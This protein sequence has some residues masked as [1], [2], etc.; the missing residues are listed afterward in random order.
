[1]QQQQGFTTLLVSLILVFLV[2]LNVVIGSKS[3]N[4]EVRTANNLYRTEAAFENAEQGVR[5]MWTQ[6]N[7][8]LAANPSA[9]LGNT[10]L[11]D[12]AYTANFCASASS[13]CAATS[14]LPF[15]FIKS[16]GVDPSGATRTISQR[17][18][19]N[20]TAGKPPII[21]TPVTDALTA[22][23][24]I[25]VGGNASV[26]SAKSG[27]S[28]TTSGSGSVSSTSTSDFYQ[29]TIVNGVET[30]LYAANGN[31]IKWTTDEFFMHYF[32]GL[33]PTTV[34]NYD[35]LRSLSD[36]TS[37][38]LAQQAGY[39]K[40]E[41]KASIAA[42]SDGYICSSS[43][44]NA[45]LSAAYSSG[46]R[47]MWLTA[48]GMKINANVVL[49]SSTDPVIIFVMESG[50]VQINGTSKIYGVVYVDVPEISST[51]TSVTGS[52][53]CSCTT[54]ITYNK[55][56]K[57]WT[58]PIYT[59]T[60]GYETQWCSNSA[61]QNATAAQKCTPSK[62]GGAKTGDKSTCTYSISVD[63]G[64]LASTGQTEVVIEVLGTWDNSGGG[65]ALIEGAA[66]T[67]GNY[68]TTGGIE[69]V[70]STGIINKWEAGTPGTN[71]LTTSSR[72]WS[73]MN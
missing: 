16:T 46:K 7:A 59:A 56:A 69:I 60:P 30:Y 64:D 24:N 45:D 65:N 70:K 51:V 33:C 48:G 43:C 3:A 9:A 18:S 57:I 36:T 62:P 50:T 34:S 15:P 12:G 19:Y 49:G 66:L 42:R 52:A 13:D 47:L 21:S 28:V 17:V 6:L 68:S 32:G 61:C 39:C 35:L 20:Y 26:T 58:D 41:V 53:S 37:V 38:E 73:D 44:A 4:L 10:K 11:T 54:S 63:T 1:M 31:K 72:G 2:T 40:A 14:T 29:K 71:T 27:G 8:T 5:S 25:A 55:P 67:S 23:G 22:L